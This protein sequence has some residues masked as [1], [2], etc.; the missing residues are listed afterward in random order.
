MSVNQKY[1]KYHPNVPLKIS[2]RSWWIYAYTAVVEERIRPYS[3]ERIKE[4][5]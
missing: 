1:R 2:P 5:R 4:H 3:W